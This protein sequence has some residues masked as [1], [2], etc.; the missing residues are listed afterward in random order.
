MLASFLL[1]G[2]QFYGY[3]LKGGWPRG[4]PSKLPGLARIDGQP[5]VGGRSTLCRIGAVRDDGSFWVQPLI[6]HEPPRLCSWNARDIDFPS[7]K[8]RREAIRLMKR[9]MS[10]R[11]GSVGIIDASKVPWSVFVTTDVGEKTT[12]DLPSSLLDAGLALSRKPKN[13]AYGLMVA[14]AKAHRRG[15]FAKR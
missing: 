8:W 10:G 1:T 12:F 14:D 13:R 11:L 4:L 3:S 2:L 15:M 9:R 5:D 6:L 7:S